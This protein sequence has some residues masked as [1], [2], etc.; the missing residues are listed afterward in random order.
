MAD[1]ERAS[2]EARRPSF[3]L[4]VAR[5]TAPRDRVGRGEVAQ[6]ASAF[7]FAKLVDEMRGHGS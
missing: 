1:G 7:G 3:A 4:D 5:T 2:Q 6:C